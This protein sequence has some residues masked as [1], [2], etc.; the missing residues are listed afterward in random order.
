MVRHHVHGEG[1]VGVDPESHP[2]RATTGLCGALEGLQVTIECSFS[3]NGTI[4]DPAGIDAMGV[5]YGLPIA[6]AGSDGDWQ[7]QPDEV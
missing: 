2:G 3:V 4:V 6:A 1:I 7:V 5:Q